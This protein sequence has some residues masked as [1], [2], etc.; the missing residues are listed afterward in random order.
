MSRDNKVN[1]GRYTA[2]GRLS[3]D[4]LSR[5]RRRQAGAKGSRKRAKPPVWET[6]TAV[7]RAA[8]TAPPGRVKVA[9]ARAAVGVTRVA[10]KTVKTVTGA[11]RRALGTTPGAG[12]AKARA[13]GKAT[14]TPRRRPMK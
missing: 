8:K 14:T 12:S 2:A 1:P 5:E 11:A 9:A 6:T 13:K 10:A 4:D 3:P 7:P